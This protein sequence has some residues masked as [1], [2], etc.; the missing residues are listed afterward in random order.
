MLTF[1][2]PSITTSPHPHLLFPYIQIRLTYLEYAM[3]FSIAL[4]IFLFRNPSLLHNLVLILYH[5]V[6]MS[7]LLGNLPAPLQG[8]VRCSSNGQLSHMDPLTTYHMYCKRLFTSYTALAG[9]YLLT[10]IQCC[11]PSSKH[12]D[13]IK[14]CMESIKYL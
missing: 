7:L 2:I 8:R 1:P 14:E 9:G 12:C 10:L 3:F 6:D 13:G 5:S 4:W 11:L